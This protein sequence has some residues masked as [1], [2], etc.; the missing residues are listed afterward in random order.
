MLFHLVLYTVSLSSSSS[1]ATTAPTPAASS[2]VVAIVFATSSSSPCFL[3][4]HR[5]LFAGVSTSCLPATMPLVLQ[6]LC[7]SLSIFDCC[8]PPV[9]DAAQ[10]PWQLPCGPQLHPLLLVGTSGIVSILIDCQCNA[11]PQKL[12]NCPTS[13]QECIVPHESL[14]YA[15]QK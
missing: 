11:A 10:H 3:L 15:M 6:C 7:L 14:C 12:H 2:S 5:L 8:V 13:L 1:P 4:H 9:A